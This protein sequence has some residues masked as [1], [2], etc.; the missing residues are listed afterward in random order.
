VRLEALEVGFEISCTGSGARELA[1]AV[2]EAWDGCL[3]DDLAHVEHRLTV[4]LEDDQDRLGALVGG[5]QLFGSD[6]P[7]VMDRLSPLVTRLAVTSRQQDLVMVHACA[8]G[9]PETGEAVILFGPSGTGKTTL[10]RTLCT[11]LAYLSDETAAL[12]ADLR[13]VPYPKPLSI[14]VRPGDELKE[15]V[16]PARLGLAGVG[17]TAYRLRALVQLCRVPDH[18]GDA[19]LEPLAILDALPELVAQTSYTRQMERPLH[20]LAGIADR[21]GGVRRAT[22]AVAVQLRPLVRSLLDGAA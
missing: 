18:A 13:V 4:V 11:E 19:V 6:L 22:Y 15:Q 1:A 17:R 8:V 21:V 2:T 3:V 9:D 14:I 20:R 10:A 5:S 16:A 7:T 12:D